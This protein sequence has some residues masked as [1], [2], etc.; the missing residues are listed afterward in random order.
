MD[1][2]ALRKTVSAIRSF[3]NIHQHLDLIA[4]LPHEDLGSFA[5]SFNDVYAMAPDQLQLGFLKVLKGSPIEQRAGEYGIVYSSRPPYEVLYTRWLGFDDIL[6]LKGIE[7]MVEIYYNSGQFTHT[8]PV[9]IRQFASPFHM[10][11]ALA[12]YYRANGY[13][14]STP[15]RIYR[16]QV[17][18]DFACSAA[19]DRHDLFVEL[20]TF[21]LYLRENLKKPPRFR[22]GK[23]HGEGS[24]RKAKIA[25][26][27]RTRETDA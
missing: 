23:Y 13:M 3:Q 4:G 15:S 1:I 20:L 16:Y 7:E 12:D 2:D 27:L 18:L 9:L 14:T 17:L 21:D 22:T 5:R 19:S 24:R 6:K 10:Y 26:I 25:P 8:L 11:G